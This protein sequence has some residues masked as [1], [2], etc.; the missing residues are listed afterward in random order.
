MRPD[1]SD[2]RQLTP[3]Y[4]NAGAPRYSP[5]GTQ[6][7]FADNFCGTCGQSDLWVINTDG[8]GLRQVTNTAVNEIPEAWSHDGTRVVVDYA[9][10]SGGT[11]GKG[12]I[13]VVAVATGATVNITNSNGVDE[14]HPD[15]R[16]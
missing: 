1:G 11:L 8:T 5:D 4:L 10:L 12:D 6:L 9:K 14:A 2:V 3:D 13:A 15:W 7:I 16:R